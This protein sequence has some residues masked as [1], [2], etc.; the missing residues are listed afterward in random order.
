VLGLAACG[1]GGSAPAED[2]LLALT[3]FQSADVVIGQPIFAFNQANQGGGAP[4]S[5]TL[6]SP[7]MPSRGPF[8]LPDI[9][10]HRVLGYD[11][12][13][14]LNHAGANFVLGQPG[15]GFDFPGLGPTALRNPQC[16]R[17]A[18]QRLLISDSGNHR[19][20]VWTSLPTENGAPADFVL[21]QPH[22]ANGGTGVGATRMNDPAGLCADGERLLVADRA[23]HRVLIWLSRPNASGAPADLVLG[24]ADFLAT[25]S[26]RGGTPGAETLREPFAVWTDGTR[27]AVA[28]RGNHR[29]LLWQ[30]FPTRNGQPADLV[31]GQSSFDAVTARLGADGLFRP[32][33]VTANTSQLVVADA[34]NHRVLVWNA[35]P[36]TSGTPADVVLGQATFDHGIGNDYDQDGTPEVVSSA[37]TFL[38]ANGALGVQ[39]SGSRLIVSDT[40]NHRVLVFQ[41]D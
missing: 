41:G 20:L 12:V 11:D 33:D 1:G 14:F 9:S 35:F 26:N 38:S 6:A 27:V 24:Q 22:L 18:G 36:S 31:L 29:V 4:T 32:S 21:G 8:Y 16:V 34:G 25:Q 30:T 19:V 40:G 28:D 39:I 7:G 17:V 2:S 5:Q 15:L 37:R 13:P 3:T 23:N 10:N